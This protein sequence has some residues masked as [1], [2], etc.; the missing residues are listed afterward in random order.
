MSKPR[1]AVADY[2]VYL[3]VRVIVCFVQALPFAAAQSFAGGLAWLAFRVDRR[4]REAA[5]DNL[6]HAFPGRWNDR[7]LD[8]QVRQVYRHFCQLLVEIVN[9]PRR[10]HVRNWQN[11]IE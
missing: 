7:E 11:Y 9:L 4:H 3:V 6:R 2:A 10:M 1:S 5:I 8:E